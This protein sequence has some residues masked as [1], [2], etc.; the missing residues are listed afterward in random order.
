MIKVNII[1]GSINK[2]LFFTSSIKNIIN[3]PRNKLGLYYS[4]KKMFIQESTLSIFHLELHN[5][6]AK[7]SSPFDVASQHF[8]EW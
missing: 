2:E 1:A 6:H 3:K 5:L 8:L 7:K 4:L